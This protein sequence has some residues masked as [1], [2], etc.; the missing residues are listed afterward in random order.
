MLHQISQSDKLSKLRMPADWQKAFVATFPDTSLDEK[1]YAEE[2][3]AFTKGSAEYIVPDYS[4][5]IQEV[6]DTTLL[7]DSITLTP[8]SIVSNIY[9]QMALQGFKISLDGHGVDEMLLGYPYFSLTAYQYAMQQGDTA[10][11]ESYWDTYL[12]LFPLAMQQG[13][14]KPSWQNQTAT[15]PKTVPL[16][17]R[18][19][20][21]V[22]PDALKDIYRGA[23]KMM[24]IQPASP[25]TEE[26]GATDWLLAH[27]A[28]QLPILTDKVVD[29]SHLN[30]VNRQ[31]YEAFH[32]TVLPTI[33]RNFD[34][35]SMQSSI[36]IRMPFMDY[37]LVS[38][39]FG[40]PLSSKIGNGFTKRILRDAMAQK[41]PESIRTRKMKIGL[42]APMVEWFAGEMAT[43][44]LD[45][46]HTLS[47]EQ[48]N[49]WNAKVL[50]SFVQDKIKNQS[51]AWGEAT[52][53]WAILNTHLLLKQN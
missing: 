46:I 49:L 40:L 4:R 3:I 8:L 27:S 26:Y 6:V 28:A 16:S 9:K 7:F 35:A 43:F 47:F 51:W 23:K 24:G 34:R 18:L 38:Y 42:N 14:Q 1:Q 11:A 39:V 33:L 19:Y 17:T 13:L 15:V 21:Q 50:Q 32:L 31:L 41:M 22:V 45:E 29:Y 2:V 20:Q 37:R 48:T 12:Q 44:I 30:P 36:E 5:L 52:S 25:V 53:F 10:T